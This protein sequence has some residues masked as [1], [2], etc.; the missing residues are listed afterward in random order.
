MS[1]CDHFGMQERYPFKRLMIFGMPGSGKSTFALRLSRLTGLPLFHL[2]KYFFTNHWQE[3]DYEEFLQIQKEFVEQE[4]WIIDGNA[5]RSLEM[6]FS[7]ADIVLYFRFNR[8]LCL[9]R[10]FKRLYSKNPHISDRAEGCKE[11]VRFRLIRYLWGFNNRVKTSIG[12]LRKT[13]PEVRFE[14]VLNDRQAD[15]FLK[16]W[17]EGRI[18]T[19]TP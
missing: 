12:Q 2:D 14:E 6:R 15:R 4:F 18:K 1:F 13:Y 5:T 16:K 19:Y 9:W 8:L 11:M 3:R 10:I 17:E 7:R